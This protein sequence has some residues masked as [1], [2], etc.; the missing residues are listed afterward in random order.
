MKGDY[1]VVYNLEPMVI[2]R[3][4]AVFYKGVD[5]IVTVLNNAISDTGVNVITIETYSNVDIDDFKTQ[6]IN[7]LSLDEVV[8]SEAV[9]LEANQINQMLSNDITDDRVFGKMTNY[10]LEDFLDKGKLSACQKQVIE[11]KSSSKKILIIG[12]GASFIDSGDI[13]IYIDLTRFEVQKRYKSGLYSN[14]MG[15]NKGEDPLRMIKRGYFVEWP[16]F[17]KHK[18]NLLNK[19]DY[20]IE[21]EALGDYKMI[22]SWTFLSALKEITKTPFSL[23]P[24]VEQ[25]IWGGHWMQEKFSCSQQEPNLAWNFNGVQEENSIKLNFDGDIFETPG[26]NLMFAYGEDVLGER[27]FGRFGNNFPIRFNFLDTIGG[28]NLSLQVHP[29]VDYAQRNFGVHYTQD[30]SYYILHTEEDG[31]IYLGVK[32]GV[33]KEPLVDALKKAAI[34]GS[35]F[36]DDEFIYQQKVKKHDHFSIP[37]GTIHSSGKNTVVLEI[38]STPNRFTFKLWDWERKDFDGLPRPVHLDHGIPNI[39]IRRDEEWVKKNLVNPIKQ[40]DSGKGWYQEATGLH[41]LEFIETR[42]HVFTE[43]VLHENHGSVNV[44][45]LVEGDEAIVESVDG[46]FSLCT[47]SHHSRNDKIIRDKAV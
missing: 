43:P 40:I 39:D 37:A 18:K 30:E 26:N 38:S 47:N 35:T 13:T 22:D 24:F 33:E 21:A 45:N 31:V 28:Q 2:I 7:K 27:V 23:V 32:N 9:F 25:G 12:P 11:H 19:I 14:W 29:K 4:K 1:K 5:E 3:Q 41:E 20:W 8:N 46:S 16:M 34:G 44:F 36:S 42:R 10:T 6:V 15:Q 17:D